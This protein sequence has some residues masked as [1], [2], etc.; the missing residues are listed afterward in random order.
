MMDISKIRDRAQGVSEG[1][2]T[3]EE[4]EFARNI[5]STSQGDIASALYIV[6]YCGNDDDAVRVERYIKP[7]FAEAYGEIALKA[8]CRYLKL[9]DRYR[10]LLRS[11]I[12]GENSS[13][14]DGR[15]TAIQLSPDY[16]SGYR[17]NQVACELV[18]ILLN[19]EDEDRLSA[20]NALV[21][22]LNLTDQVKRRVVPELRGFD[23]DTKLILN[24]A[25]ARFGCE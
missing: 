11:L 12:L 9:I 18:N 8:L 14:P 4:L 6:G 16:L 1:P 7:P 3:S 19:E 17:D 10:P 25:K 21:R 13:W 15:I 22:I 2:V 24:L 23:Q 5:L 20:R